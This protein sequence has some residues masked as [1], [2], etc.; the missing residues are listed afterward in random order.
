M[1]QIRVTCAHDC[2]CM[3][4]LIA[5][6]KDGKIVRIQGD[7]EQPF[8]D[9]FAC[10]KVNRDAE[11]VHSPLRIKTPLRRTGPKGS[12]QFAAISWSEALDEIERRWKAIIA[13]DGPLALLG[14]SYSSHQ[15]QMNRHM[16]N[17]FFHAL[18]SSRLDAGTV[19]DSCANVGWDLTLGPVGCMDPD[20]IVH[21]DLIV[22]WGCDVKAVNVHLWQKMEHRQKAGVKVIVIDPHRNRTAQSADWHLPI[23]IGTDA[24]L[25]VG[26]AHI[27]VR[28][29]KCDEAYLAAKTLGFERWKKE[30]LPQFPP[31][32]TAEITGLSVADIERLAAMYGA[33]KRSLLRIGWGMTR[34]ALGGQAMRAVATLPALTG[35]YGTKGG[36]AV[37]VTAGSLEFNFSS[38]RKPSGPAETRTINHSLLGEA[39]LTLNDPPIKGLFIASNNPA[40]TCPDVKKVKQG[41]SREDLFTVVHDPMLTDTARYADIVL[42]ATTYL[43]TSDF[44]RAYGT[45]YVQFAPSAVAPQG[46]AWS[47]MR[48]AQ[49]LARRMGLKDEIFGLTPEQIM[50]KFFEGATGA[51]S[52]I[53][54]RTLLDHRAVKAAPETDGQEFRTPS[55]RLE[56]Y[57]AALAAQGLPPMPIWQEDPQEASDAKRWPLRLL[58]TPGYFLSH[59]AF[60]ANAFLREREGAPC[61]VLHPADAERRGLKAGDRVRVFNDRG[62]V[63]LVLRVSDEIREGIA[64]VPGQRPEAESVNGT[65]NNLCSDR[66]T[67]I[68]GGA[69]YQSTYLEVEALKVPSSLA[70]E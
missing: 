11:V 52:K 10:G 58:T 35:A 53:D 24:A 15:G 59:T 61:C 30:V 55:G 19:C 57:S 66:L 68:G 14:Y 54:P 21:S 69:T 12:G 29:G 46:E 50:P 63:G 7:S 6:V 45:Y 38:V 9:G 18:G 47:N 8:T 65:V 23:K 28:D 41:L 56:I 33:T 20:D 51:V 70:A 36:G 39:L 42:P 34:V 49:E 16:P 67:D 48:L 60:S 4:S 13:A 40:V 32:R 3:C 25:A 62:E 27:L 17:G 2:P 26:I 44:Y 43:E 5:T 31:A 1:E 22:V 64:L 37:S